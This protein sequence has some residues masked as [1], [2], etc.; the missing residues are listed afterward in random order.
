MK[1]LNNNNAMYTAYFSHPIRG[2]NGSEATEEDMAENCRRATI[3]AGLVELTVPYLDLYVPAVHDEFVSRAYSMGI[4]SEDDILDVDCQILADRHLLIVYQMDGVISS[5][6]RREI[7]AAEA[8]GIPVV[9]FDSLT[10]AVVDEIQGWL[11]FFEEL[12]NI[13]AKETM[14]KE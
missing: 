1:I 12:S 2:L 3:M 8:L 9:Y 13:V 14:C 7:D 5:G 11:L 10:T 4:V 6:M